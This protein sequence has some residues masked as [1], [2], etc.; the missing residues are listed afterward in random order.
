MWGWIDGKS[1]PGKESTDWIFKQEWKM[2]QILFS[3]FPCFGCTGKYKVN[4][5]S[6]YPPTHFFSGSTNQAHS[7]GKDENLLNVA[8]CQIISSLVLLTNWLISRD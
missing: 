4:L 5:F 1:K 2:K 7:Y 3:T 6:Y 8:T